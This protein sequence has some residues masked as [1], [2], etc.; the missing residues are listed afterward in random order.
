LLAQTRYLQK[1]GFSKKTRYGSTKSQRN[2]VSSSALF[3][4]TRYLTETRFLK[5]N[6][7]AQ[8]PGFFLKAVGSNQISPETRFLTENAIRPQTK[9]TGFLL[10]GFS[11]KPD[12][13]QKPGFSNKRDT[14]L[15]RVSSSALLGQTR[16]LTE[17]RFLKE[18]AIRL[19]PQTKETGFLL[20]GFSLKP[21]ISQ[22]PG[23]S[24]KTR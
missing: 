1:P 24:K 5:E 7:I 19:H 15:H 18:N 23:F 16:Y 9:E 4:Q 3:A 14:A 11:L 13:S 21:D 12:I 20:Q 10:Q 8:K 6:A 2:R 22:K 17:T